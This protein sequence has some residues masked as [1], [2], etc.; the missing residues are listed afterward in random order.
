MIVLAVDTTSPSGSLA[1]QQDG[2]LVIEFALDAPDGF[3]HLIFP[4]IQEICDRAGVRFAKIDCFAAANGPGSFTGVRVGVSAVK[5]LAEALGKAAAGAST[6]RALSSFGNSEFRAV[7][8]DTHRGDVYAAVYDSEGRALMEDSATDFHS[9]LEALSA[10]VN[11]FI[12]P[13]AD[14]HLAAAL[15]GTRFDGVSTVEAPSRLAAAVAAC[16]EKDGLAGLWRDP[17]ALDANYVREF[18]ARKQ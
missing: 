18:S 10:P 7:A 3:A 15:K 16:A 6:L 8:M 4:A 12:F 14:G 2:R 5:G 11:Q 13:A 1:L 17:A 9:W